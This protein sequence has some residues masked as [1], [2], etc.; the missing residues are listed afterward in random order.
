[1]QQ[2]DRDGA[3]PD[4][5]VHFM[6]WHILL[7]RTTGAI[8]QH[9]YRAE[10]RRRSCNCAFDTVI[11]RHIGFDKQRLAACRPHLALGCFAL[12]KSEVV[13]RD[14]CALAAEG[15]RAGLGYAGAGAGYESDFIVQSSHVFPFECCLDSG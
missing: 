4:F 11:A 10:F 3:L 2:I 14:F 13:I 8:H 1:M 9:V 6:D 7:K 15:K 12:F 5:E